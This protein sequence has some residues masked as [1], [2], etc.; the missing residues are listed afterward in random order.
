MTTELSVQSDANK[1][2]SLATA[3]KNFD[4][5]DD[6]KDMR[7]KD[8]ILPRATLLQPLSSVVMD[9]VGA[10][11]NIVNSGTNTVL[12]TAREEGKYIVPIIR[13]IEWLEWNKDR[14]CD[15]KQKVVSRSTDPASELARRCDKWEVHINSEGKEKPTVTE[16]FNFIVA[17]VDD[18]MSDYESLY[19]MPFCRSSHRVGKVLLNR[20]YNTKILDESGEPVQA[21][22]FY[23]RIAIKTQVETKDN[24]KFW[25]PVLGAAK[26]NPTK[27]LEKLIRIATEMRTR[28]HDIVERNKSE[29]DDDHAGPTGA[30]I[31]SEM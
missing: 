17:I 27:D 31:K 7:V 24:N 15:P 19:V 13:W 6:Y 3:L 4:A 21:P 2:L 14:D 12:V 22:M 25:V 8:H 23:N 1:A 9:G 16:Y 18:K 11:G 28:K 10:A 26:P 20:L 5:A 30:A 29:S